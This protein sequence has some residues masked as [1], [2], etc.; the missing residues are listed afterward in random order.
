M[1]L[2]LGQ[3]LREFGKQAGLTQDEVACRMGLECPSRR[4]FISELEQQA[5]GQAKALAIG[6]CER[7][8]ESE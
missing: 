5:A 3:E 8:R 4:G 1:A 2:E 7:L 6:Q